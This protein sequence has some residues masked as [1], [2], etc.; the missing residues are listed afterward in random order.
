MQARLSPDG[1]WIAFAQWK[2]RHWELAKVRVGSGEGPVVLRRDG[3]ANAAPHWSPANDWITWE[4][5]AGVVLV[6]PD[7]AAQ[8]ELSKEQWLAH[9][10]SRDGSEL[11]GIK[12]T[13][14]LRLALIAI[15]VGTKKE[16]A[17]AD[18]GPSFAFNN[19]V[20]G[21]TVIDGGRAI[22][23]SMIRPR[24]DLWLAEGIAWRSPLTRALS[25]LPMKT[26]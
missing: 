6:S 9:T 12:E 15:A 2:D 17:L 3:L 7:G 8:R 22:A 10:W 24:G 26:P 25:F 21:L 20:K 18:L 19:P 5:E 11:L 13:D 14:D 23:T 16:T 1:H 4:T